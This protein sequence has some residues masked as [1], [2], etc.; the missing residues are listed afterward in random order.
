MFSKDDFIG[1]NKLKIC[2][3]VMN[4]I[5]KQPLT[6]FSQL[7]NKEKRIFNEKLNE[8]IHQLPEEWEN[9]IA[10]DFELM[11]N[12]EIFNENFCPEKFMVFEA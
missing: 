11:C 8:Y 9:K 4:L 5:G 3:M 7:L 6:R 12:D 1:D 2:C 10:T